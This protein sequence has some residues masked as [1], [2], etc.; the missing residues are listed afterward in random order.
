MIC[1]GM[2]LVQALDDEEESEED[3]DGAVDVEAKVDVYSW[4]L[5]FAQGHSNK[6][7]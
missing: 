2:R 5:I 4:V 7:A 1:C 3:E 6:R